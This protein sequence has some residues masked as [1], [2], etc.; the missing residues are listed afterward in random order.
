MNF[1][2][3]LQ[4][5]APLHHLPEG[6]CCAP[7]VGDAW[8][9][10]YRYWWDAAQRAMAKA[11]VG[12]IMQRLDQADKL[13]EMGIEATYEALKAVFTEAGLLEEGE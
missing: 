8:L 7:G 6:S 10:C 13:T 4:E 1:A 3:R 12:E 9:I 11:V 2:E 5:G